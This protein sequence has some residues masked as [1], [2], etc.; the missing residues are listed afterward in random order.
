MHNW[1]ADI[2][3][4]VTLNYMTK[5]SFTKG[6]AKGGVSVLTV[7]A[8]FVAFT[9]FSDMTLWGLLETYLKPVLGSL[10]VAGVITMGIN[11]LKVRSA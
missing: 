11:W 7:L 3:A 10:T 4:T 2:P 8:A 5:Y 9:S 6:L 1:L